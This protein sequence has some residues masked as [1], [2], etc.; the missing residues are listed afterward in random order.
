[1]AEL[2]NAVTLAAQGGGEHDGAAADAGAPRYEPEWVQTLFTLPDLLRVLDLTPTLPTTAARCVP[3][4]HGGVLGAQQLGQQV[5]LAERLAPGKRVDTLHTLFIRGGRAD[6]PLEIDVERLAGGRSVESFALSLHQDGDQLSRAQV[7]LSGDAPDLHRF[8]S[9]AT[10]IGRPADAEPRRRALLPWEVA[11]MPRRAPRQLDLWTRIAD[12]PD[13]P[14]FW[15][16]LIA[17]T[18]ETLAIGDGMLSGGIPLP[19]REQLQ[20]AVLTE[21][22]TY[23]DD[24]DVRDWHLY[25]VHTPQA[26]RGRIL[27][28][29]ELYGA[30]GGLRA[31][32]ETVNLVRPTRIRP[33]PG[34]PAQGQAGQGQAGQG[35]AG[36]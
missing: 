11:V 3:S 34:Q 17:H 13:D 18:V 8:D 22:V 9:P 33:R 16:A 1:M 7:M 14:T 20:A 5:V 29:G 27:G 6:L 25:R 36:Q 35:Q 26:G 12:A 2:S 10:D 24:L 15:R 19:P 4:G 28:R 32:F 23:L 31:V 30:D 21:T